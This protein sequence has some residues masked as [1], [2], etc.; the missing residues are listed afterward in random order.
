MLKRVL[1]DK[2]CVCGSRFVDIEDRKKEDGRYESVAKCRGCSREW[3][4]MEI[5]KIIKFKSNEGS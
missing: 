1:T 2:K 5:K 3:R 4:G